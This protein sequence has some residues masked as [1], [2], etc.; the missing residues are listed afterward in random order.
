MEMS[1]KFEVNIAH[2]GNFMTISRIR[3]K[4]PC[5]SGESREKTPERDKNGAGEDAEEDTEEDTEEDE[6]K[7]AAE[8]SSDSQELKGREV[9]FCEICVCIRLSFRSSL[10]YTLIADRC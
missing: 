9:I 6:R 7:N 10:S 4:L 3:W 8:N 1:W 2:K 5:N